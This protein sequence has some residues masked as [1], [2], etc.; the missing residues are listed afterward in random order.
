MKSEP[1]PNE[2][3]TAAR[4]ENCWTLAIAAE[5]ANVSIEAYSRWEYGT[6][7]PRLSSLKLLC[8][9]FGKTAE[10][11]GFGFLVKK[12][13][14]TEEQQDTTEQRET[15][16]AG[17]VTLTRE[18][19]GVL[20]SLFKLL[21]GDDMMIDKAKRE[22]LRKIVAILLG[23]AAPVS[24]SLVPTDPD[25]E[26]QQRL[27][28]ATQQPS[29]MNASTLHHFYQLQEA[30][31]GLNNN[32]EMDAANRVLVSFLPDM[33]ALA[34]QQPD[35][36]ILAAQ[37]LRLLSL[38]RAHQLKIVDMVPL[39]QQAVAHARQAGS[40]DAL[41]AALNGL[42]VAFKYAKRPEDSFKTYQEAIYYSDQASPLLRSRVYAGAAAAFAQRDT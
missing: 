15:A 23:S 12:T 9:A 28:A 20:S 1:V 30:C 31:W 18:E 40:A 41:S 16:R 3:L 34:P 29:M 33:I 39:C 17:F 11:L 14:L 21:E 22:T 26:P 7:I 13:S 32:G 5:K 10:E 19:A 27:L 4:L 6:Q 36:A 42:A 24:L 35:A 37:G 25:P 38:L 2:L 8:D